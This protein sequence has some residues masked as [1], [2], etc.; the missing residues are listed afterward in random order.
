MNIRPYRYSE[1]PDAG[2]DD[3]AAV[4]SLWQA[5]ALTR[6]WNDPDRDIDRKLALQD[7]LFLV[8]VEDGEIIA[9]AMVGYDGHR[10]WVNYLAVAPSRQGRGHGRALMEAA[11]QRLVALGC[12]K[13]NL[14]VRGGN[15]PVLAFYT[16]L[17]YAVDDA[18]S[19]GKRLIVD[20]PGN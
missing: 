10:G 7:D 2:Q 16:A 8:G 20:G 5:C 4:I 1:P 17:G 9:T 6:P 14:Q 18:V 11:E 13:L 19:L 15:E 12:P 3:R